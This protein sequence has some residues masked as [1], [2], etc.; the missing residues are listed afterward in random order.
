MS[1]NF[2]EDKQFISF[3]VYEFSILRNLKLTLHSINGK[4]TQNAL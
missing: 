3:R 4:A 1:S 2:H